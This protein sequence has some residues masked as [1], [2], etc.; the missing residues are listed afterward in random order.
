MAKRPAEADTLPQASQI[1][2]QIT[3]ALLLLQYAV[4]HGVK[5]ADGQ[6]IPQEIVKTIEQTASKLKLGGKALTLSVSE[7][8]S[9]EFAYYELAAALAPVTADTLRAT[10]GT[11]PGENRG[12]WAR[13]FQPDSAARRFSR[14]LWFV[15]LF[16]AIFVVGSNVYL[17]V[18][19]SEGDTDKYIV[20][21]T[22]LEL[23]VPW[24]YGALGACVYLLRS[25]H[26]YIYQ[27]TFD[28]RR[29]PEYFNRMLLGAI[30]GGAIILFVNNIVGD[31]GSVIQLGSAAIGFLAGYNTDL[32]FAAMERVTNALLPKIGIETV[33]SAPASV[34]RPVDLNEAAKLYDKAK[35]PAD[36]AV[37]KAIIDH[38]TGSRAET[39]KP[40]GRK[41]R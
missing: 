18:K 32:L 31:D 15:S 6:P 34:A 13:I 9:F 19:A 2:P 5:K 40:S 14:E 7:R 22:I 12:F 8:E 41:G 37:H 26:I 27:R 36:K 25:A 16:L 28:V 10:A 24:M 4:G 33:Q 21:R 3:D 39:T 29:E 1:E 35:N 23:L 38:V 20:C 30:S 17:Q 11:R